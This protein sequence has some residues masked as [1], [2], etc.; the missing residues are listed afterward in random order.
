MKFDKKK[1]KIY[2]WKHWVNLHWIL[3]P[4][5]AINE[6]VFGQR[7]PKL[8]IVHKTFDKNKSERRYVYCPN[9]YTLHDVRIWEIQNGVALKNWFGLYCSNCG[10]IIPCLINILSLTILIFTYPVRVLFIKKLK[11]K[12]LKKQVKRYERIDFKKLQNP[13]DKKTWIKLGLKWGAIMFF[14]LTFVFPYFDWV[15]GTFKSIFLIPPLWG[16]LGHKFRGSLKFFTKKI[17]GKKE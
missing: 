17:K 8:S 6:L 2:T 5:M 10:K 7:I 13:L 16:M 4:G 9:C 14:I 12:W 11:S 15:G 1:Y 3:N